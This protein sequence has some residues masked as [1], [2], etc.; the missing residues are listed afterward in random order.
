MKKW[1]ALDD[2]PIALGLTLESGQV[3]HW[4]KDADECWHG[5]IGDVPVSVAE[6]ECSL[7]VH[8]EAAPLV[9]RYFALDHPLDVIYAQFPNDRTSQESLQMC[10]GLRVIRQPRW[11]CLAT[12]ITSSMKQ[13]AHI[14][15]MSFALRKKFG[16]PVPGSDMEAYPTP[17]R[18]AA[19]SEAEL[20]TCGLGYRAKHLQETAR[21][22]AQA[23]VG[24]EGQ[25]GVR[26]FLA[27]RKPAWTEVAG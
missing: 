7:L 27:R 21:R 18:L 22:I 24:D 11:E 6:R 19:A 16:R 10:R 2:A 26:A 5:L 13:V 17:E 14:R 25:E 15:T 12:F 1:L 23:R 8:P 20:R 4:K 9:R 3:F